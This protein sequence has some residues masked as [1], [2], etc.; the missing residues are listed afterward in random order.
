MLAAVPR[1]DRHEYM[2]KYQR[3][4]LRRRRD[5]WLADKAC[6]VCG[7]TEALEIDHVDPDTK[8]P[9]LKEGAGYRVFSWRR[10]IREA[11]LA[12]CQVLCYAHHLEK[13][14]REDRERRPLE[15]GTLAMYSSGTRGCRCILCRWVKRVYM[16]NYHA[17]QRAHR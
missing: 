16:S 12:K 11:E 10:G 4:W 2:R 8:D 3:E 13:T 17:E 6:V 14:L 9:R 15:H 5:S 7:S 1:K